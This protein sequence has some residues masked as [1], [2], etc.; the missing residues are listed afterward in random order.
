MRTRRFRR[1][2][3][4]DDTAKDVWKNLPKHVVSRRFSR[5]NYYYCL[6]CMECLCNSKFNFVIKIFLNLSY[7]IMSFL[8]KKGN[9]GN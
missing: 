7:E 6:I 9:F 8:E 5:S 3:N 4:D 2:V 1:F